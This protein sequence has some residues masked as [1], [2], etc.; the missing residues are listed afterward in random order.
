MAN[1]RV[2]VACHVCLDISPVFSPNNREAGLSDI[3]APGKL[4]N[5]GAAEIHTGG[6]VA[7]T[8]LA[9]KILGADVC[10]AGKIG[11][12]QFGNIIKSIFEKYDSAGGLV[13][14]DNEDTSY[15]VV[16]AIPGIDRFFLHN[17]GA[18]HSFG[19]ADISGEMLEGISHF[20]LGYPPLMR[21]LYLDEGKELI[22]LFKKVKKAGASTSL[23]MVAI[24]PES[25]AGQMNWKKI[26]AAVMPYVDF[27]VPSIEE[28]CYML[29][30]D[31]FARWQERA[32]GK[33]IT[34]ILNIEQDVRPLADSLL[35]MGA[36]MLLIKCGFPGL[37]FR[38]ADSESMKGLCREQGLEESDWLGKEGFV[39]SYYQPRVVSGTGAGDTSIAAFLT[40]ML[41]GK[42]LIRSVQLSAAAGASCVAAMDALSGLCPLA[43]LE[44][45]IEA[46]WEKEKIQIELG[47]MERH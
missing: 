26:L 4:I 47:N 24:D 34:R 41:E 37:Y 46:G 22:S 14:T 15:T 9:M 30:P 40:A 32:R 39:E 45:R 11:R 44:A 13:E 28:L 21:T 19:E 38:T 17:P 3:L 7:N 36:K 33:D 31:L 1:K 29:D 42:S 16:I 18:N 12:D 23:D 43:E 6:A 2:M 27:F 10:L 5:V 8:G 25:E 20:H 35:Q